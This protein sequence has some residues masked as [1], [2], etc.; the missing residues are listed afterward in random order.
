LAIERDAR[1]PIRVT[2]QFYKATS[3]GVVSAGNIDAIAE[4]ISRV[5]R[6]AHY[7]GSLVV[8]GDTGRPT[9]YHGLTQ[10][11]PGWWNDFWR[12][13][14]QD[15]GQSPADAV[16][17]LRGIRPGWQPTSQEDLRQALEDTQSQ[18]Y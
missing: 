14:Q 2:V 18:L 8:S 11:P 12:R 9:E 13:Y 3:N 4:Q 15:T 7:V 6:E 10:Q 5:Y 16:A 17:M 1:F